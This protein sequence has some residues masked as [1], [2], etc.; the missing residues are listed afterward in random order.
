MNT[1]FF[2][3]NLR[4]GSVLSVALLFFGLAKSVTG[5][6]QYQASAEAYRDS[7]AY[8]KTAA[9]LDC[10][11]KIDSLKAWYTHQKREDA[12]TLKGLT[13]SAPAWLR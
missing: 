4:L 7:T 9:S 8:Y 3:R 13:T 5:C 10:Q 2:N 6:R 1:S 11:V 12:A